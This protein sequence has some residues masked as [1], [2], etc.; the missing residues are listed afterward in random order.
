MDPPQEARRT[1]NPSVTR[2][3]S[4]VVALRIAR[5]VEEKVVHKQLLWIVMPA[6][7]EALHECVRFATHLRRVPALKVVQTPLVLIPSVLIVVRFRQKR[8]SGDPD[9]EFPPSVSEHGGATLLEL[10]F[11]VCLVVNFWTES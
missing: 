6:D 5:P 3:L 1:P 8:A 7:L 4:R 11:H 2:P 9:F 10:V